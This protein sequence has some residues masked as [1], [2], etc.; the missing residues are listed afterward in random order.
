MKKHKPEECPWKG[1]AEDN[2][3]GPPYCNDCIMKKEFNLSEKRK[4]VDDHDCR[5]YQGKNCTFGF[6]EE[7]VKEFIRRVKD[8]RKSFCD[9]A[10]T[11]PI[12]N[13]EKIFWMQDENMCWDCKIDQLSGEKLIKGE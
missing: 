10:V 2:N 9:I 6:L 3:I 13:K 12:C 5:L 4:C 7:D 11:C 1:V 8:I